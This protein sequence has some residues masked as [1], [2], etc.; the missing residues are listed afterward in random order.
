MALF[1]DDFETLEQ[2]PEMRKSRGKGGDPHGQ[3]PTP[4]NPGRARG[5]LSELS[6]DDPR[7]EVRSLLGVGGMGE[8]HFCRDRR[9]GRDVA[10]KVIRAEH[11]GDAT[12]RHRFIREARV[13]G[14][15]EHPS[16]VPVYDLGVDAKGSAYFTMKRLRGLTL[17]RILN[18]L[19]EGDAA[20]VQSFSRRKL[21]TAFS[22]ICLAVDFAHS[23]GVLHRDLK[24]ANIMLGDFGEVYL[25]DWGVAKLIDTPLQ[26][27][28]MGEDPMSTRTIPGDVLG[29]LGYM[30]PEQAQGCVDTLDPRSDVYSL[31]SI[32]FELLTLK[33]LHPKKDRGEMLDSLIHGADARASV[34]APEREVPPELDAICVRATRRDPADRYP[35]A[36]ALYEA[37]EGF[38]DGDRDVELRR[39]LAARHA[40]MAEE[41]VLLALAGGEDAESA[42]K[43][44]LSEV[45]QALALDPSNERAL[46][47]LR[48]ILTEP[49]REMPHEVLAEL[50]AAAAA[51]HRL[52]LH[53]GIRA[54]LLATA[55]ATLVAAVWLGVRDW[56]IFGFILGFTA[57]AALM[58][59]VAIRVV[60]RP[61][62]QWYAYAGF[63][64]NVLSFLCIG[65]G[66]GPLLFMPMLLVIFTYGNSLTYRTA[67]R[68]AIV[69][70][71]CLALLAAV[72][73]EY[74]G[75]LPRSYEFSEGAMIILPQ[76]VEHSKIPTMTALTLTTL[77][78]LVVPAFMM[79]QH[80]QAL[81]DAERRAFLQAWQLRQLLPERAQSGAVA[82]P[83]SE[84]VTLRSLKTPQRDGVGRR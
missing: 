55:I 36:R 46:E 3:S 47:T 6:G 49:P 37:V 23:R 52:Q 40:G 67:Y 27:L 57:L 26:T 1:D 48:R 74:A 45:G 14:Q 70:T 59:V 81:R 31:G 83:R 66:F 28:D 44:L 35:S 69:V 29:T 16:I 84:Q 68:V 19:R 41:K 76:A 17:A 2:L 24:P 5:E 13:Q 50:D 12:L 32:L 75:L 8:V 51:R 42:R 7:Y 56:K 9:I 10:M 78:M 11:Q 15:L 77:F 30:S 58:K 63:V 62:A 39:D 34:R 33:P 71:G 38:L 4:V 64:F 82:G 53:A 80:Q 61:S 72:W 21:L 22:S 65:R 54:E 25:L 60:H 18:E 43:T 20:A 79:G 73:A